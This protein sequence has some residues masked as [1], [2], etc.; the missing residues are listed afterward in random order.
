MDSVHTVH[1]WNGSQITRSSDLLD[2]A[3]CAA[4][5]DGGR[6]SRAAV[7]ASEKTHEVAAR[8]PGRAKELTDR[9]ARKMGSLPR[10]P[11]DSAAL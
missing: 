3:A 1:S 10:M 2:A 5:S 7:E 11:G 6:H 4:L 9:R 8:H